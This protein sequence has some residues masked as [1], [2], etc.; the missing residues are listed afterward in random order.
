MGDDCPSV[1]LALGTNLGDRKV[2]LA[3]ALELLGDQLNIIRISSIYE[4]APWGVLDQP[5][6]LNLV[7]E[8]KTSL[9]PQGLLAFAKKIEQEMGREKT[10]RYGPRLID[11]DI[12]LYGDLIVQTP[13]LTIPHPRMRERAFVMVPLCEI[14]PEL[15]LPGETRTTSYVLSEMDTS[16]VQLLTD[17]KGS[18]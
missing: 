16:S 8:A 1:Y 5:D 15:T 6:F 10:V 14:N 11:V 18:Q 17:E 3:R 12:L 4:T 2:N 9:D 13:D 7:L